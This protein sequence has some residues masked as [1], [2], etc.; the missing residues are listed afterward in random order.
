MSFVRSLYGLMKVEYDKMQSFQI[1]VKRSFF[2][3]PGSISYPGRIVNFRYS[4]PVGSSVKMFTGLVQNVSSVENVNFSGS[5]V[6]IQL[7]LGLMAE[8][9]AVGDSVMVSGVCLT[10]TSVKGAVVHFDVVKETV[11]RTTLSRLRPGDNVNTE[12]AL[13]LSD[14]LGGHLV[15]GH[16]DSVGTIR[17][18]RKTPGEVRL[19]VD[20][21]PDVMR[22]LVEKGSVA[23][24]GISLTLASLSEGAFEVAVIPHTLAATTLKHAREGDRVNL[25]GDMIG[26][27]VARFLVDM[28]KDGQGD[29]TARLRKSGFLER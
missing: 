8:E 6:R 15:S 22:Y 25:E 24:D 4:V 28:A 2:V 23:I 5:K 10:A 14:R 26:R 3:R 13:R 19:T 21:P 27:W 17:S 7:D 29:L 1:K 18:I 12:L 20:A 16:V 9:V 11:G